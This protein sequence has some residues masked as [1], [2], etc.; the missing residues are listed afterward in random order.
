[1]PLNPSIIAA[2][3]FTSTAS[4]AVT[5]A[6]ALAKSKGS[7]LI[8]FN[9]F[10]LSIHSSNSRI[11]AQNLQS[12]LDNAANRLKNLAADIALL[13]S[14]EVNSYC[15]FSSLEDQLPMLIEK[16]KAEL[17]VMGM[18]DRSIEQDFLGNTT[19]SII[20]NINIPVLAVPQNARF[21][22][23]KKILFAFESSSLSSIQKLSWFSQTADA[24][25]AEVVFFSVDQRVEQMIEEQD[26]LNKETEQPAQ[27]AKYIYKS[28]RSRDV[29]NEIKK[30]IEHYNADILVMVPQKYGFW[31]SLVHIS[32]TRIMASGLNIPL[33]SLPN[34]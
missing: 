25:K 13:Y 3:N 14:I 5:Y 30:E 18:A 8:L 21:V 20:K 26:K 28:I 2:T 29:V 16:N 11:S 24:L 19:T 22:N 1:M 17:V 33:L 23:A 31:D 9:S 32:K 15:L 4:N 10:S 12:E 27:L 7:R 34:F 6:A